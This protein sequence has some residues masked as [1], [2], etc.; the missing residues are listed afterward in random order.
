MLNVEGLVQVSG[1]KKA[2]ALELISKLCEQG[3]IELAAETEP[4]AA[5]VDTESG[6]DPADLDESLDLP[7]DVQKNILILMHRKDELTHYQLLGIDRRVDAKEIKRAYFKVSKDFHPDTFFRKEIGPFKP[8]V[9]TLFKLISNAYEVLS[10]PQKRAAYD[11]TLP[12]EPTPEEIEKD[13]KRKARKVDDERLREERRRRLIKRTPLAQ[14]RTQARKHFDDAMAHRDKKDPV[15]AANSVRL[16]LALDPENP[17]YL[18][19]LDQVAG[20]ASEI[21][22]DAEYKR[23]RYE[24]SIGND[25]GALSAYLA[26][27]ELNPNGSRSLHRAAALMLANRRD[28]KTALTF[29]RKALQLEPESAEIAKTTAELYLEMGM[30]KNAVREYT[31][32]LQLNP[33]DERAQAKLKELRKLK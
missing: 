3:W 27:I 20:R 33:F 8:R 7:I 21:R 32:Y 24:E 18:A 28:L 26:A 1:L 2:Q 15:K 10:N 17:E 29:A 25:E 13:Q 22:G 31:R 14:R 23:G 11:A 6:Y 19:L 9:V 16:A 12:Y 30:H 4:K 5:K